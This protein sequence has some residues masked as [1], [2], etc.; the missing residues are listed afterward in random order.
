MAMKYEKRKKNFAVFLVLAV[1]VNLLFQGSLG[2]FAQSKPSKDAEETSVKNERVVRFTL[3]RQ[4]L[5][6]RCRPPRPPR[7]RLTQ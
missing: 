1:A 6:R 4:R 7:P 5:C 2:V 3:P